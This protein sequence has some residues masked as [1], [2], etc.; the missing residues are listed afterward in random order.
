MVNWDQVCYALDL[1]HPEVI[2]WL[3]DLFHTIC[4]DWGYDYVKI[5]FI[6]AG[7]IDGIRHDPNVTRAQAYRR[8]LEAIRDAVGNRFILACGN[9]IGPSVGA[10]RR[11]AHRAGRRAV[12][13]RRSSAAR[14]RRR[15]AIRRR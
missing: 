1:T 9:P 10:R 2:A 5:D 4:D 11:R 7:A 12:L 8:G 6:Y 14:R 13:A 3:G 15:S